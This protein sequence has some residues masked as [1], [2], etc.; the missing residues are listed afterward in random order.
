MSNIEIYE[1]TNDIKYRICST[2]EI[3][4]TYSSFSRDKY[5]KR[6][7]K[8]QCRQC[9]SI[10]RSFKNN[11]PRTSG[12]KLC[13]QC[14]NI[15]HVSKFQK[16][17]TAN[18]GLS[19][20]CTYCRKIKSDN[21]MK[22]DINTKIK[23]RLRRRIRTIMDT[24]SVKK[25]DNSINLLGCSISEY[26]NYLESKFLDGMTWDNYGTAWHI[27]H[28]IPLSAYNISVKENQYKAF[29]YANTQPLFVKDNLSKGNR[30]PYKFSMLKECKKC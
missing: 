28:I 18:D 1:T 17:K 14:K 15:Y 23:A 8:S 12:D 19:S 10:S 13:S 16:S 26:K 4:M 30:L 25:L 3:N 24:N 22:S 5:K 6:G 21:R 20:N 11:P 2:C 27:D 29:Y 9:C 7:I